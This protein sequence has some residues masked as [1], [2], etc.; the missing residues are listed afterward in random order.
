MSLSRKQPR[1]LAKDAPIAHDVPEIPE[2]NGCSAAA[3]DDAPP[4]GVAAEPHHDAGTVP[5]AKATPKTGIPSDGRT[6]T[7]DQWQLEATA[8]PRKLPM[9][10]PET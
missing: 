6:A 10:H 5:G 7:Q 2:T 1:R 9:A 4:T 8:I 3:T